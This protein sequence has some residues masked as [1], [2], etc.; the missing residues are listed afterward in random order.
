MIRSKN[1][2]NTINKASLRQRN[3]PTWADNPDLPI[4]AK[5]DEIITAIKNNPV[6]IISGETGSGKT[7][8]IPKFSLAAGRGIDGLIG[9]TQPRRIAA[10]TVA[11]RIAEELGEEPGKSVGYKIR[12]KEKTHP[13]AFIKIMTDGILLAE[14]QSD[15]YLNQY[16]TLIVDEAHE[17]SL[18]IDFIL[19]ILKTLIK[20]RK[21]LKLIIT[22]ATIDTKKFSKAFDHAPIIEVSGRM[23]PVNV[24]YLPVETVPDEKGE[25]SYIEMTIRA[26]DDLLRKRLS[27]DILVF[28]PTEQDIRETCELIES[29]DYAGVTVLPLFARLSASQ[30]SK[31]F[32]RSIAKKIIVATNIAETSITIPGIKYVI[33][34]GLARISQYN[35]RSRTTAL[36]ILPISRSSADQRKGRCGRVENGVCIR[37]FSEEDFFSRPL[38]TQP[39]ILRANLSEVILRMISLK[40]GDIS[41]FPFIDRPA[42]KNTKDAFDLL[43]ELEA[44]IPAENKQASKNPNRFRLTQKGK[45]MAKIPMDPRLSRMLIEA[46]TEDCIKEIAVIASVLSLQDPR[47]RPVEKSE[48]ADRMHAVFADPSSDFITLLNIWNRYHN[49]RHEKKSS[50]KMKKFCKQ[51]YLSFRRMRE[52]RDI[53]AQVIDILKEYG[54]KNQKKSLDT[55]EPKT[56]KLEVFSPLYTAIHKSILSGFISNIA[57]KK[58]NN[59]F[60]AA[61]DKEVMI[62]PGS[63]LFNQA[64]TW[65]VAAEMV[66]TSR[67]FA[68]TAA[69]IDNSWLEALG[70]SQCRYSYLHPHWEKN[71]GQVIADEQVSLYGLIIVP[72]RKVSYG[73][74]N[75]EEASD[76]FIRSALIEED[77]KKPFPF[78]HYNQNIINEVK[79]IEDKIRRRDLLIAE[80]DMFQFYKKQLPGIYDIRS[81]QNLL[82][83]KGND[84]FLKMKKADLLLY[85]PDEKE[86]MLYPN[87]ITLGNKSF[88]CTYSFNPGQ[89]EDGVTIQ[90]PS[91]LGAMVPIES[92]DWIV[93]GLLREKITGL[94]KGLPKTYRKK[95]VPISVTV[96]IILN[97]MPR[98][99]RSLISQLGKFIYKRFGIDIPAPAWS[100][101]DL[102]EHLKIR[103]SITDPKGE[104]ICSSRDPNVLRRDLFKQKSTDEFEAIR[105]NWEKTD[106]TTWNF[107]DL[108]DTIRLAG[109]NGAQW[110]VYP[111]LEIDKKCVALRLF[112]NR[113]ESLKSHQQG[114]AF[115][116]S[117]YFTKDLKFLRKNLVLPKEME[118]RADYFGGKNVFEK[119]L[120]ESVVKNLFYQNIRTEKAFYAYAASVTPNILKQGQ[121]KLDRVM[122]ILEMYHESRS[123]LY[124]LETINRN[125]PY[126]VDFLKELRMELS[127]LVPQT[128]MYLY[129]ADRL[130]HLERY[131]KAISIR[132]CRGFENFEKDRAKSNGLKV[133]T[134]NLK[135]L[136]NEL[137][138]SM[139]AEKKNAIEEYFWLI[140]EY[141]VSLFAQELKTSIPISKKRLDHKLNEIER[142]V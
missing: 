68:R 133:Y 64:K 15:P 112:Q 22:S 71:Q 2:I 97:E 8:Q 139:S 119:N 13:D 105:K 9:C 67:L 127:K 126:M 47:E 48:E 99:E 56:T 54:L 122:P 78:M 21:D 49:S 115:L 93:P 59:I 36:P 41:D 131:I 140:E 26:I 46:Q 42:Q 117:L 20:K 70:K 94:L 141:K 124:H 25:Q 35:P 134:E 24:R 11:N 81:L 30:Q 27:G 60:K 29:R 85:R 66:E 39:E 95:L 74:I 107:G 83:K 76:I 123:T 17:R 61:K 121:E 138:E 31:V 23:Y 98:E 91:T 136:L 100:S 53:H 72:Q 114:V 106:I 33:D 102:P 109:K 77:I 40:L 5:K 6:V 82:K 79:Q 120:Y 69:N 52:W 19:G 137:S 84:T 3:K 62:F 80:Q 104:E 96:D 125:N 90:V 73:R 12:F 32:A 45:L 87:E 116:F 110:M 128:F 55:S 63:N 86:L 89:K 111:G 108:P 44:I 58:E 101:D 130:T 14:T 38:F 50:G 43:I 57:V 142:M 16:D 18:N 132:G 4:T 34:T 51:H 1:I 7:T 75:P 135:R 129:D 37:L 28:M 65:I 88:P 118:N 92:T 10:V 113:N 103:I